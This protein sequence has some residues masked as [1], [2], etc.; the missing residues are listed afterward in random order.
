MFLTEGL[1]AALMGVLAYGLLAN[2]PAEGHWLDARRRALIIAELEAEA[3]AK[4]EVA[5]HSFGAAL[6]D[7]RF[8]ALVGMSIG[9]IAGGA[10][11]FLCL[12]T[13]LK[14]SGVQNV[15]E[16]GLLSSLPFVVAIGAQ[17]LWARHSDRT[18]ERRWHAAIPA[19]MMAA[20]WFLVPQ[21]SASTA[22][23]MLMLT[24]MAAGDLCATGPFWTMPAMYLSGDAA[25]GGI[26]LTTTIGGLGAFFAPTV[27]G[28]LTTQTGSAAAGQYLYAGIVAAGAILMLA[29]TRGSPAEMR[30]GAPVAT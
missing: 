15:W 14:Q 21:I 11:I 12:P 22:L 23:A 2:T 27:A 5:H 6:A 18:A 10:G 1:P 7:P 28:Y 20:G 26:A 3:Q 8:Y 9:L 4:K 29:G 17:Q 30:S 25:A 13:I 16:I 19:L 24:M